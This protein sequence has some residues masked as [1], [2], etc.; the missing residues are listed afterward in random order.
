[1]IL[2]AAFAERSSA[3]WLALLAESGVPSA[4][5]NDVAT[6]LDDPQVHARAGIVET[7]HPTLGAVRQVASPLRLGDEAPNHRAPFRGEHTESVLAE[8]CGYSPDRIR[9]LAAAGAF[10]KV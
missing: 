5:V 4:P 1:V 7:D 8:V 9:E 2:D 6:A 10:G 3:D